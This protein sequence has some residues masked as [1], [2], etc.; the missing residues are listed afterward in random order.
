M[1]W[2]RGKS[3]LARE[4]V[5]GGGSSEAARGRGPLPGSGG[6]EGRGRVR[7]EI[8]DLLPFGAVPVALGIGVSGSSSSNWDILAAAAAEYGW[9]YSEDSAGRRER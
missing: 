4:G 9:W 3:R 2:G 6:L 7:G 5:S 1:R 8:V